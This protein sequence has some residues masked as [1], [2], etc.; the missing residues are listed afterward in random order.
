MKMPADIPSALSELCRRDFQV[1]VERVF[2]TLD[3]ASELVIG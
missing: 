3:P 2:A 1:F